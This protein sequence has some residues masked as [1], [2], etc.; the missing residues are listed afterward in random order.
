MTPKRRPDRTDEVQKQIDENLRKVY[1]E[2][3]AEEIPGRFLE[4]LQKLREQE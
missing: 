2:N 3:S 4:L 1:E